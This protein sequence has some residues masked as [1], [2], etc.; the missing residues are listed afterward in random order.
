VRVVSRLPRGVRTIEHCWIA[1]RDGCRLAARVWLPEDADAAPVPGILE[2]IPYRKRDLTRARDEPMH[3]YFAGH[4]YAAVRVDVRGSGDSEGALGDEYSDQEIDDGLDVIAWIAA[5]PWCTGRVGMIGKSWGGFNALQIA[6]RRPPALGAVITVCGSDDRYADDAHYMGGCLLNENLVWGSVLMAVAALPPDPALVGERWRPMWRERLEAGVFFPALWLEHQ[7][8]DAYWQRGSV[9]E[10][11]A[12][13]ACPVYAVGG[14]ADA[15]TNAIPRLLARLGVPRKGLVGPWSHNYPHNG[16]PGPAIGFLQEALRWWDRWLKDVDTGVMDEPMYRVWMGGRWVAE[17]SWPSPRIVPRR[18]TLNAGRL[19]ERAQP[20]TRLACRSPQSVGAAA[21]D[22]CSVGAADELPGDQRD[23]DA[24]SLTFDSAPLREPLEVFGAPRVVLDV[25]LDGAA[26]FVAV[27]LNEV[28]A[29]GRSVR[30]AYGVLNLTHRA[31]HEHPEPLEPG[32]RYTVAIP[33]GDV[34]HAFAARSRLRVAIS[35]SYWPIV[36]PSAEASTL[37]VFTG[38]SVLE[39]PVRPARAEDAD[40][41]PF[42]APESAPPL[43]Y[44]EL[45]P[46][47]SERT[48]HRDAATGEV[49]QAAESEGGGFG[50]AGP[51]RIAAIDLEVRHVMRRRYA[52]RDDDPSS[53]R[54]MIAQTFELARGDWAVRVEVDV[55][56]RAGKDEF[57]LDAT[58]AAYENG[59]PVFT[60]RSAR[61]IPRDG[62]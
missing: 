59:A 58:V 28:F 12:A 11:Y 43:A 3:T 2:Y 41:A 20:A 36:W 52:I 19:D 9:C 30:V 13:I 21:G 46:A 25:A 54:A 33:L 24:R 6:A 7:R 16:L 26:G 39:L 47:R 34:A 22:W 56:C 10:D 44:A 27:R 48:V 51:S 49:V 40:L 15:Y 5:Q 17:T 60:R 50:S 53:A 31:G 32:A 61:R 35:T 38:T 29:D 18:W 55:S 42:A 45:R 8:R 4:G 1:V 37:T 23:D 57:A 14:W 62:V